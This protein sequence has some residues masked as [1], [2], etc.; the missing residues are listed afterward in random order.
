VK[1]AVLELFTY[2]SQVTVD[3]FQIK[4]GI[5]V[6]AVEGY[7]NEIKVELTEMIEKYI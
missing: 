7:S 1:A 5:I 6:H 4:N 3:F 2:I